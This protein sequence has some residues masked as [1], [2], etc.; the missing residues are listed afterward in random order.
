MK[1]PKIYVAEGYDTVEVNDKDKGFGVYVP[2]DK[3]IYLAGDVPCE[4]MLKSLFHELCHWVQDMAGQPFDEDEAEE[5]S[6][7]IFSILPIIEAEE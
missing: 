4:V 3:Q 7:I 5:F 6:E 1:L 2:Q